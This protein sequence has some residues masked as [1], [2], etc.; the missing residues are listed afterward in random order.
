MKQSASAFYALRIYKKFSTAQIINIIM[1]NRI[2][3]VK[4]IVAHAN[5]I[6]SISTKFFSQRLVNYLI[7][8]T[9]CQA[10]TAGNTLKNA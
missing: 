8:K 10:L 2:M 7:N 3:K 5:T 1:C 9:F 4:P 6:Y